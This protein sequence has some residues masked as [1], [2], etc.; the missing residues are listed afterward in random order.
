MFIH[1]VQFQRTDAK[2]F[3]A[4]LLA[5][6]GSTPYYLVFP[7]ICLDIALVEA[8]TQAIMTQYETGI[9]DFPLSQPAEWNQTW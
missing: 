7:F 8:F 9:L 4:I 5:C 6:G 3:K 1:P 2:V